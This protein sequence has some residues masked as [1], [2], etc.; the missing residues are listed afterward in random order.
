MREYFLSCM[1]LVVLAACSNG[2]KGYVEAKKTSGET[3]KQLAMPVLDLAKEYSKKTIALQDIADVEYVVLETH[4]DGLVGSHYTTVT[5]SLIITSDGWSNVVVFHRDGRFSHS[6]DCKGGSG[7]EY[8]SFGHNL[9]V[10]P[11][12]REIYVYDFERNRIQVYS[13]GGEYRRTLMV[14]GDG[15]VWGTLYPF[16]SNHLLLED[17]N[18]VGNKFGKP[19]NPKPYYKVSVADGEMTRLPFTA[20]GRIGNTVNWYDEE[21]GQF[22]SYGRSI[23]SVS[24]INGE[25]IIATFVSDTLYAYRGECLIPIAKKQNWMKEN[26]E[27]WLVTLDGISDKYYLWYAIEKKADIVAWR[28]R[29]FLQD[30]YTGACAQIKLIDK[31][32]IDENWRFRHRASASE[33]C[34]PTNCFMQCYPA[35]NLTDL[36][37]RGKLQGELK[38]IASKLDAEDNPVLMIA[39]FK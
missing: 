26:G 16:D 30:R 25:L 17:K 1:A 2:R 9:C 21:T 34:V 39:T 8:I 20:E 4:D 36:Y 3:M 10:N 38:E 24:N 29:T 15:F 5:D 22:I 35:W 12:L 28:E 19:T 7:E 6:F 14:R 27:P 37:E 13:Y 23:S 33:S 18:N 11:Q 31:N 32:I